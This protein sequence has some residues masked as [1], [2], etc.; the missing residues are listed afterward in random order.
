M[1]QKKIHN[2]LI[3]NRGEIALR[4]L[5]SIKKEGLR[6]LVIYS[7]ADA[8]ALFVREADEAWPL[9]SGSLADT[10]LN[11]EK[12][13]QIALESGAEAIHPGYGFLAE[14]AQ[15]AQACADNGLIFI[16]PSAESI[17]LMGN[18]I[19]ARNIAIKNGLPVTKGLNGSVEVLLEN[20][21][22]IPLPLLVKAAAGGGGKGMRIVRT[23]DE[24]EEAIKTTS[25][26]ASNYFG[27]GT[28]YIEQYIEEPRHIEIQVLGDQHGNVIHLFERECSIQRRYQ[29]IIEESPSPSL[30]P[31]IR[32]EMGQ[33]AV[34][35]CK[36]IGYF[37]AGTIEFLVDKE[38]RYYFL[39]MNTRIQVEH[40]VTEMVSGVDLVSAQIQIAGGKKLSLKQEDISA[41]GHAIECRIYAED[42]AEEFRPSPGQIILY[43]QPKAKNI[44]VDSS[45]DSPTEIVSL[46]DPMI[47]KLISFG[48]DRDSAIKTA[49]D[50]LKNYAI[51]G[52]K[53]NIPFLLALL[54]RQ[55]FIENKISTAYCDTQ[56]NAI[57]DD[58]KI[59]QAAIKQ[60]VVLA[61]F[62]L[63]ELGIPH[64]DPQNIWQHIG[65]W[66]NHM[67][68][69]ARIEEQKTKVEIISIQ[70]QNLRY[71]AHD[72]EHCVKFKAFDNGK[73][74]FLYD[75]K[76]NSAFVSLNQDGCTLIQA[77]GYIFRA[78]RCNKL[79]ISTYESEHAQDA[80]EGNLFAPMPGKVIQI[81]V[82][83]NQE[84]KKGAVLLI[85]EAMKMENNIISPT[86]AV[87]EKLNVSVGEMVDTKTQL[88]YLQAIES[89][90]N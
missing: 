58:I 55:D 71:K 32:E 38:L 51:H 16:G 66:R 52:I 18:K 17:S 11:I 23:A 3:A 70:E 33:A 41:Q 4:I 60:E 54:N 30:S 49:V 42:P 74:S 6:G 84:V 28:V 1:K 27:D 36:A 13:I 67:Q 26:E 15:F 90:E 82:K 57:L 87:V 25:R 2:I 73:L 45:M 79:H 5:R 8:S 14:N 72:S 80:D 76:A 35:L 53:T 40:P 39:E 75:D 46:Y 29:K 81:N 62:L 43:N 77:E 65:F 85:V 7:D 68:F 69:E 12:I 78:R 48:E 19:E 50:A 22:D 24:L 83:E 63:Y 37:S 31:K 61:A 20:A 86:D 88:I 21:K 47:S 64:K 44:R 10:Y 34:R 9:G 56:L 59:H 89:P